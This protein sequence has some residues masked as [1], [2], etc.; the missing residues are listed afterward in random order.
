MST[1]TCP[2]A[3]ACEPSDT[4]REK[5]TQ[6]GEGRQVWG[7]VPGPGAG[8][9]LLEWGREPGKAVVGVGQPRPLSWTQAFDPGRGWGG[10]GGQ[11]RQNSSR[12]LATNCYVPCGHDCID[13]SA[14]N[15]PQSDSV[16]SEDPPANG[17]PAGLSVKAGAEQNLPARLHPGQPCP[18]STT[19]PTLRLSLA[20]LQGL[21]AQAMSASL[22]L[23]PLLSS[24][25][26]LSIQL[27]RPAV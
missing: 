19:V 23:E 15:M 4:C 2:K 14:P 21:L 1:L 9:G 18:A 20:S 16:P 24:T 7:I 27:A 13:L 10:G 3:S 8:K 22:C 17:N 26:C 11:S 25:I 12:C 6:P 5:K